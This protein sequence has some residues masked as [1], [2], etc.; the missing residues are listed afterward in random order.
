MDATGHPNYSRALQDFIKGFDGLDM[1]ETPQERA[2]HYNSREA[3]KIDRMY[4]SRNLSRQKLG[5]ETGVAAFTD[6]LTVVVRNVLE[7]ATKRRGSS[8]W[9]MNRTLLCEERFQEQLG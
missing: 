4:G 5:A 8:Y 9:K 6:H 1:W 7:A 2:T 3:S